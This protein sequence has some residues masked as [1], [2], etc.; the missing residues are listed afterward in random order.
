MYKKIMVA[1]DSS[2]TAKYALTEAENIANI[3]NAAICI[4]HALQGDTATDTSAGNEI[5]AQAESSVRALSIESR[6][7]KADIEYGLNGIVEAIATA[8][9]DWEADLLVVG[10]ANRRGLERFFIGSVAEQLVSRVSASILLV[11]PQT[12]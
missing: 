7:V 10:T 2:E 11:R 3:Y 12:T 9:A 1:V 8:A 6:L 4:V 5:L